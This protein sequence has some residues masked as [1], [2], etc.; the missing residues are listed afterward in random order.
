MQEN[1]EDSWKNKEVFKKQLDLNLRELDQ[2]EKPQHWSIL[3]NLLSDLRNINTFLDVGCGCGAVAELIR[4]HYPHIKYTGID[5]APQAIEIAKENWP[6]ANFDVKDYRELTKEYTDKFD[7]VYTCSLHNVL[8]SGDEAL[9]FMLSLKP[10]NLILGKIL[11]THRESYYEVYQA[12]N[13][14]NTYVYFHNYGGLKKKICT[15]EGRYTETRIMDVCYY[16]L[17]RVDV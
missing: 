8:R 7:V 5:Y 9:D 3:L 12:Y 17:E 13:L 6:F 16:L 10:K 2:R 14:I 15:Y 4:R 1:Y 11:T